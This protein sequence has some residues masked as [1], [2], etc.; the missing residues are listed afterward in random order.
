[1]SS[2]FFPFFPKE[3]GYKKGEANNDNRA[4][5]YM[6]SQKHFGKVVVSID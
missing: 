3:I 2:S 4:Y 5:E 6:W 1:V